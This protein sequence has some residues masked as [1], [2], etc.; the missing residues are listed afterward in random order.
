MAFSSNS[1]ISRLKRA[2]LKNYPRKPVVNFMKPLFTRFSFTLRFGKKLL[3]WNT[4]P[5]AQLRDPVRLPAG[6]RPS[7][8]SHP[9]GPG[10]QK[11]RGDVEQRALARSVRSDDAEDLAPA[12]R[13]IDPVKGPEP[14]RNPSSPRQ[15]EDALLFPKR[16]THPFTLDPAT[17]PLG[18]LRHPLSATKCPNARVAG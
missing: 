12:Y 5:D 18:S 7:P 10:D 3:L 17:T 15:L 11:T 14:Y 8:I 13:D 9:A 4:L 16:L 1:R 2:V 6:D